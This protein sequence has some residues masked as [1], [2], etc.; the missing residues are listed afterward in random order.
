MIDFVDNVENNTCNYVDVEQFSDFI[1]DGFTNL[2]VFHINIRSYN[3]NSNELFVFM[4]QLPIQPIIIVLTETWF[5]S[6]FQADIEGYSSYHIFRSNR[7][8]G[9]VS[10]YVRSDH[11]SRLIP[12]LSF[13]GDSCEICSVE[14]EFVKHCVKLFAVY[15]PPDRDVGAFADFIERTVLS[16]VRRSEFAFIAGDLNIDLI[17]PRAVDLP[18]VDACYSSSFVPLVNLPTHIS[19]DSV[20]KCLDHVWFNRLHYTITAV[21]KVDITDHFPIMT[22]LPFKTNSTNVIYKKFRY[23]SRQS[24]TTLRHGIDVFARNFI[25]GDEGD[26]DTCVNGF[27]GGLFDIYDECCPV[28][29][30]CFKYNLVSK[31]WITRDLKHRISQKHRLF[32]SYRRGEVDFNYYNNFKNQTTKVLRAAKSRYFMDRKKN[33]IFDRLR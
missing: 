31:P 1:P 30:K 11:Q 19:C 18:F 17:D 22:I 12:E 16:T 28:R 5:T 7:R 27:I 9:G 23:H 29:T 33:K 24:L 2:H 21:F 32:R 14:I 6:D 3:S 20:N 4:H 26:V 13:I 8:G 10:I 15:R 25:V